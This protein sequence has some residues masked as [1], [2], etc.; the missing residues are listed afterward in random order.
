MTQR[1]IIRSLTWCCVDETRTDR[2]VANKPAAATTQTPLTGSSASSQTRS[3]EE[4][5]YKTQNPLCCP[6]Q[7]NQTKP[8]Q[9][10]PNNTAHFAGRPTDN[11]KPPTIPPTDPPARLPPDRTEQILLAQIKT[12]PPA[13]A[14]LPPLPSSLVT[15]A[16]LNRPLHFRS[17]EMIAGDVFGNGPGDVGAPCDGNIVGSPPLAFP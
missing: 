6:G 3:P 15:T 13:T 16:N 2:Q 1:D 17:S 10:R 14:T 5:R 9:A 12:P 4:G 7:T 11:K 8:D